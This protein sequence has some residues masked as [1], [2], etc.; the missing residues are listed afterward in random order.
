MWYLNTNDL[1]YYEEEHLIPGYV[2]SYATADYP[3][4]VFELTNSSNWNTISFSYC[5]IPTLLRYRTHNEQVELEV[6][7][8]KENSSD[9][10]EEDLEYSNYRCAL[11]LASPEEWKSSSLNPDFSEQY[12]I[13]E[14]YLARY[15][16]KRQEKRIFAGFYTCHSD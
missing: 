2:T 12:N 16:K 3:I 13:F 7:L 14:D 1:T 4:I 10:D 11:W 9:F 15:S 5:A 6:F 8:K